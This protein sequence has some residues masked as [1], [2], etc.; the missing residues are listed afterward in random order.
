[1]Q[2]IIM[3][4]SRILVFLVVT[5]ASFES[6]SATEFGTAA[7]AR[8]MLNRAI[9]ALKD[10]PS[11]ALDAFNDN[12][13]EYRDRDLYIFCGGVDGIMT[14]HPRVAGKFSLRDFKDIS[15]EPVG[16]TMYRIAAEGKISEVVYLLAR[17]D[18]PIPYEKISLITKVGDQICGVGYYNA[19][20]S[21]RSGNLSVNNSLGIVINGYDPVAYFTLGRATRGTEQ[22]R[23]QWLGS[24]WHFV[25][26]EHRQMFADSTDKFTPQYGGYCSMAMTLG[27]L[28]PID[29]ESWQIV[30]GKLY[31]H[32]SNRSHSG[33]D[34]GKEANIEK[35]NHQ[36]EKIQPGLTN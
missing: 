10:N 21:T 32:Y 14:A 7:E 6:M 2:S 3:S 18:D 15:G 24:D 26:A 8:T 30:D 33:W 36:W 16:E 31:L 1:M 22:H 5:G 20:Q 35:A 4:W 28:V 19:D 17:G 25:N 9:A 13:G 23:Y 27:R 29:P 11:M 34:V 12:D